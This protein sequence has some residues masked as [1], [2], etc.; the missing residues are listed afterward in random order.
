MSKPRKQRTAGT[1][2][3]EGLVHL[4]ESAKDG[5]ISHLGI[6]SY[7][8]VENFLWLYDEMSDDLRVVFCRQRDSC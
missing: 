4:M 3:S 7:V 2:R 1:D 8:S 5:T 6:D